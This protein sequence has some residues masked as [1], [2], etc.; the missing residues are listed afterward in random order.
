L[1][2][3][4]SDRRRMLLAI[5]LTAIAMPFLMNSRSARP[6]ATPGLGTD[7]GAQLGTNTLNSDA[8]ATTVATTTTTE[9]AESSVPPF[10]AGPKTVAP[11]APVIVAVPAPAKN[12]LQ[13]VAVYR[14][15]PATWKNLPRPCVVDAGPPG[16]TTVT[17]TNL[18]NAHTV[19]CVVATHVILPAGHVIA[20]S[21]AIFDELGDVIDSPIPVKISWP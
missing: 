7:L 4:P 14:T 19:K 20:L 18:N 13:G 11:Q 15:F 16:G 12:E 10:L 8:P 21:D 1:R 6:A 9:P 2:F 17:V 5:V 3:E